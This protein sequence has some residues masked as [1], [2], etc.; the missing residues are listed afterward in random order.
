MEQKLGRKIL[1]EI[2][3]NYFVFLFSVEHSITE[4]AFKNISSYYLHHLCQQGWDC[5]TR[6]VEC[7]AR[8][9]LK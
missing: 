1:N 9:K 6:E 2:C 4:T 8:K 3:W 5:F 7:K